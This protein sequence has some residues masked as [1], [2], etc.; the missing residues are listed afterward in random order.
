MKFRTST[1]CRLASC[2]FRSSGDLGREPRKHTQ[3]LRNWR[4]GDGG[5]WNCF[6]NTTW[7]EVFI[8]YQFIYL[9][10][11]LSSIFRLM[12]PNKMLRMSHLRILHFNQGKQ[13]T[14]MKKW[15][16][17]SDRNQNSRH[18]S[19]LWSSERSLQNNQIAKLCRA[20]LAKDAALKNPHHGT[21]TIQCGRMEHNWQ[22]N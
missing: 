14:K 13:K 10:L 18:P 9:Q 16:I 20:S 21:T 5:E 7:V 19:V 8:Y 11:T 15:I 2:K 1:G 6:R 3:I 4:I 12:L 22:S 17:S